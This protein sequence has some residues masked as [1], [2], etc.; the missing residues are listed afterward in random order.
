MFNNAG[1]VG[2]MGPIDEIPLAEYEVTMA[3]LLRSVFLGCTRRPGDE[4]TGIRG[5]PVDVGRGWCVRRPRSA[6]AS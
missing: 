6:R 2:A 4:T 1:I 5:H 3:V